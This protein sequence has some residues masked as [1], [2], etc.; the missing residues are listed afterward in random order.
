MG[1]LG[2]SLL[3]RNILFTVE[4]WLNRNSSPSSPVIFA[5]TSGTF[6][7]AIRNAADV[8]VST[9]A[10]NYTWTNTTANNVWRHFAI[11]RSGSTFTLYVDGV[12][13]GN[14]TMSYSGIFD[15]SNFSIGPF[16]HYIDEFRV[17]STARYTQNFTPSAQAFGPAYGQPSGVTGN[18]GRMC[19]SG[20]T[21]FIYDLND[22]WSARP[23]LS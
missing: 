19:M 20:N 10:G 1:N 15:G 18:T 8:Y 9:S 3:G 22:T 7:I 23:L 4:L 13:L 17:S 5:T 16:G 12:S 14:A 2:S 11:V 21:L 6:Q